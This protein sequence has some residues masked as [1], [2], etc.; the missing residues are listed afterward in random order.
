MPTGFADIL[1]NGISSISSIMSLSKMFIDQ[2]CSSDGPVAE[3]AQ[4]LA[5]ANGSPFFRLTPNLPMEVD[6][7]SA[8]D[9]TVIEL[10]WA[11]RCHVEKTANHEIND[12]VDLL[13]FEA[14]SVEK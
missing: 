6:L 1:Q 11:A 12:L 9:Q 2:I 4:V 10:L 5:H 7:D 14:Q 8:D 3:R 13:T